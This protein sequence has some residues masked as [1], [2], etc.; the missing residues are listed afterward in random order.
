MTDKK[1]STYASVLKHGSD[2]HHALQKGSQIQDLSCPS[3]IIVSRAQTIAGSYQAVKINSKIYKQRLNLCQHS[4]IARVILTKGD[5]PWSFLKLKE[6][7]SSISKISNW[8]FI[9]LGK[10]FYQV[11]LSSKQDKD[12]VWGQGPINLNP[13]LLRLQ[14]WTPGFDPQKVKSTNT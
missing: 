2:I 6:K 12:L 11:L 7:L 10:G 4:L 14:Q 3:D 13:G 8:K 5:Q 1:E 9:S